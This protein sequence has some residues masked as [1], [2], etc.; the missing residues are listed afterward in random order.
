MVV[1]SSGLPGMCSQATEHSSGKQDICL[2]QLTQAW[3]PGPWISL[4]VCFLAELSWIH[5]DLWLGSRKGTSRLGVEVEWGCP[6]GCQQAPFGL[7]CMCHR[8]RA[9]QSCTGE[10]GAGLRQTVSL[11]QRRLVIGAL[12]QF[13]VVF[14]NKVSLFSTRAMK[15]R[16]WGRQRAVSLGHFICPGASAEL[17]VSYLLCPKSCWQVIPPASEQDSVIL[18]G[19]R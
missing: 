18:I 14:V 1:T 15:M 8:L 2:L 12:K 16:F 17:G 9:G 10:Q 11:L 19:Y 13:S 3:P 4:R 6:W 5:V 7:V